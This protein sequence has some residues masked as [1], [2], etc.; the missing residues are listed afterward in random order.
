MKDTGNAVDEVPKKVIIEE[1]KKATEKVIVSKIKVDVKGAVKKEG[2]YEL[3]EGARI[4]DLIKVA[5]GLKSNASTKYLNLSKKLTDEM[6][7][8]V[9]TDNK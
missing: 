7:V 6:V 2:V 5:G 9:Y 3:E 1:D 4:S 8:K